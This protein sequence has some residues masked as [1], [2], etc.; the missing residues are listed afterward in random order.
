MKWFLLI[1]LLNS[2]AILIKEFDTKK[3]CEKHKKTLEKVFTKEELTCEQGE[4]FEEYE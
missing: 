2:A 4:I 1:S 3:Q